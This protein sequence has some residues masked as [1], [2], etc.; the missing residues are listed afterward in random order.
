MDFRCHV[1]IRERE[2]SVRFMHFHLFP[3]A[4]S[5]IACILRAEQNY[6][7]CLKDTMSYSSAYRFLH[8]SY[9]WKKI[10]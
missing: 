3:F 7:L 5:I 1:F 8:I 10:K 9:L 2:K 6:S 4:G